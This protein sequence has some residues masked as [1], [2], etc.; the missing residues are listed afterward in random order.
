MRKLDSGIASQIAPQ[1]KRTARA[2]WRAPLTPT[3]HFEKSIRSPY[4][5]RDP[6]CH[7]LNRLLL[8]T[9]CC[10]FSCRLAPL[11]HRLLHQL[12][13]LVGSIEDANSPPH[14]SPRHRSPHVRPGAEYLRHSF[15]ENHSPEYALLQTQDDLNMTLGWLQER[16]IAWCHP[17]CFAEHVAKRCSLTG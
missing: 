4:S 1:N 7:S 12:A 17:G 13:L 2:D 10:V 9:A 6:R 5:S 14:S 8:R 15:T 16:K 11:F 3:L